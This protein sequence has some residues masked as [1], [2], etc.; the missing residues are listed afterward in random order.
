MQLYKERQSAI[1]NGSLTL[2]SYVSDTVIE[3]PNVLDT[4]EVQAKPLSWI[5]WA[6]KIHYKIVSVGFNFTA[7]HQAAS[8]G[9]VE[10]CQNLLEESAEIDVRDGNNWTP[11]MIASEKGHID[12]V[13]LLV[14]KGADIEARSSDNMLNSLIIALGHFKGS[15]LTVDSVNGLVFTEVRFELEV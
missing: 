1:V 5:N 14:E 2:L 9:N 15:T 7:L 11:L 8:L 6:K 3:I 4:D 10:I 13:K 12:I